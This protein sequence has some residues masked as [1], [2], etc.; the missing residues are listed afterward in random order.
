MLSMLHQVSDWRAALDES[1]R[2][3]RPGG[4]LAV[5]LLTADHLR[6]VTWAYDLFP[7]A[8]EFALER[9]PALAEI[10]EHLPGTTATAV[11][12]QDLD[13]ASI[14]ALCAYPAAM[15]DER[16]RAQTS[17]FERLARDDPAGL[18]AGL[19]RLTTMVSNG[20]DPRAARQASRTRLGDA[21]LLSWQAPPQNG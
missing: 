4:R 3:L 1:A 20:D 14:A 21:T 16:L 8:R 12:F 19:K 2:V 9:R 5:L 13:D 15:L 18:A 6:E 7:S 11:W 10:S 17:F